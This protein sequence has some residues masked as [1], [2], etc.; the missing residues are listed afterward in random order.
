MHVFLFLK[1]WKDKFLLPMKHAAQEAFHTKVDQFNTLKVYT[2]NRECFFQEAV[3]HIL[4]ELQPR[5]VFFQ[6][7]SY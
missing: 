7:W 6:E 2:S 1:I 4:L 3:Y 5:K